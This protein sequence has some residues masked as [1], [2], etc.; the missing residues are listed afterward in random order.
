MMSIVV[1]LKNANAP[2]CH[3]FAMVSCAGDKK[4]SC[5]FFHL[6]QLD[7]EAHVESCER[8]TEGVCVC[9]CVCNVYT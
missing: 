7:F 6:V 2:I 8:S 5:F 9:V 3:L 1:T 4:V